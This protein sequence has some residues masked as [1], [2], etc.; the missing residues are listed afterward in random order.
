[1]AL[2]APA[3]MAGAV[4]RAWWRA[5]PLVPLAVHRT[6]LDLPQFTLAPIGRM[7]RSGWLAASTG[8]K[9]IVPGGLGLSE[10]QPC[11]LPERHD[12]VHRYPEVQNHRDHRPREPDEDRDHIPEDDG[13][14]LPPVAV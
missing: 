3:S 11:D 14:E 2:R 6:R 8:T 7:A 13:Q 5:F 10:Y 12:R 9:G 4:R 1:M